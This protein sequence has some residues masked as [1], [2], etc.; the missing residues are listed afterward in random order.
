MH[1]TNIKIILASIWEKKLGHLNK[2][3]L[4]IQ[5]VSHRLYY[6]S[7]WKGVIHSICISD[8]KVIEHSGMRAMKSSS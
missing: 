3:K 5:F 4:S 8:E 1:S 7:I 6:L 2:K